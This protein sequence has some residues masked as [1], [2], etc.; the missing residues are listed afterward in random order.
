MYK[1]MSYFGEVPKA[2][3]KYTSDDK[4]QWI[5]IPFNEQNVD[6]VAYLAWLDA[7][8]TPIPAGEA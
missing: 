5:D 1:L 4:L 7:G 3:R 6:Y 2:V 8:N